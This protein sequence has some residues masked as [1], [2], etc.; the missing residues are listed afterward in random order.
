MLLRRIK[1]GP[2]APT[3][4]DTCSSSQTLP[5][6]EGCA[7]LPP[8]CR[9]RLRAPERGWGRRRRPAQ[10]RRCRSSGRSLMAAARTACTSR[11]AWCWRPR[12]CSARPA[13]CQVCCFNPQVRSSQVGMCVLSVVWT[14][15]DT[16][17]I[18]K[19]LA[20]AKGFSVKLLCLSIWHKR[21]SDNVP[22]HLCGEAFPSSGGRRFQRLMLCW[23]E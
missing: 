12:T 13:A 9:R 15:P 21:G 20:S 16:G 7:L 19:H 23:A 10:T 2:E 6:I 8:C 4:C 14:T 18:S 11:S 22:V 5:G 1:H 17:H 3:G